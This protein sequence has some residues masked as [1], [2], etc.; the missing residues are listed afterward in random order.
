MVPAVQFIDRD[1]EIAALEEFWTS[2]RAQCIGVRGR[3]RVG[4]TYLLEHFARGKR[5]VYHRCALKGT[6]EQLYDLGAALAERSADPV[7]MAQPP[8]SWPAVFAVVERLATSER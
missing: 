1:R 8:S 5:V 4:K 2:P 7:L 3:R 6:G